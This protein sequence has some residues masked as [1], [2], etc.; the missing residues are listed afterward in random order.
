MKDAR[1]AIPAAQLKG[2]RREL[3][4]VDDEKIRRIA[5]LVDG[6]GCATVN[7]ALLDPVRGRLA[8]FRPPRPLRLARLL[9]TP[10]DPIILAPKAWRP[11]DPAVPRSA[12]TPV[13][14]LIE[15]GLGSDNT[16]VQA[17]ILGRDT[18]DVGAVA[19]AGALLWGRAAEIAAT[20]DDVPGWTAAGLPSPAL[21]PLLRAMAVVWRRAIRLRTLFR[22]GELGALKADERAVNALLMDTPAE[23]PLGCAMVARLVLLQA[24]FAAQYVRLFSG[25]QGESG[26]KVPLRRALN[27]GVEE[28]VANMEKADAF[29]DAIGNAALD[30]AGDHMRT[31][32]ALLAQIEDGIGGSVAAPRLKA[33]RDSL[34]KACKARFSR[35]MTEALIGPLTA[36]GPIDG[37]SQ[38][39]FEAHARDLRTLEA[40]ARRLGGGA[41]YDELLE[42]GANAVAAAGE[43]GA[44]SRMARVRLTEILSGPEAALRLYRS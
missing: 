33:I 10:F 6:S 28:T 44:L 43:R 42:A 36:A 19:E 15:A 32:V 41:D 21:Q 40:A 8:Q 17:I 39:R 38:A 37:G 12:L 3:T 14:R 13:A 23:S 26:D 22:D 29:A 25:A 5:T 18:Q 31:F 2:L 4:S 30:R 34:A 9:F 1:A 27:R 35:G 16:R 24:P 7:Q 20:A 11:D